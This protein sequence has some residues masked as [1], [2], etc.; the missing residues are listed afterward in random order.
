MC[1]QVLRP[2][3]GHRAPGG[4]RRGGR[5]HRRAVDRRAG[6]AAHAAH[7]PHRRRGEPHRRAVA[8][9]RPRTTARSRFVEPRDRAVPTTAIGGRASA[10]TARSSCSTPTGRVRQ[11][12]NVPYGAHLFVHGRPGGRGRAAALR[13]G[14]LQQAD[15]HREGAARCGSWTS[16]RRSR[17]ATRS[18]TPPGCKLLVIMEDRN[19][20][21]Q[22]AIDILD[23]GRPEARALPAADRGAPRGARR[24]DGRGRR[25]AG[26]DP[27]R[28]RPRPATSRAVCRASPSCSRRAGRRTRRSSPRSTARVEFGG[29]SRGMRKLVVRGDD[30]DARE[31]LI[32]QGKHLLRAGGQTAVRA[33]DRLTEG[34]INPHDILQ[35]QGHRGGAGVP[36]QRDPGGL[37]AAGRAHR[38][39]AHRGDRAPDAPEGAHRGSGRHRT[40]SRASRWTGSWCCEE[41]ER[42][43]ERGRAAGHLPAAAARDHQGLALDREL[44]LGG[45]LPGDHPGADRGGDPGQGGLPAG[46]QG[47]RHH[48]PPDPGRDRACPSYRK[49]RLESEKQAEP[50]LAGARADGRPKNRLTGTGRTRSIARSASATAHVVP[51]RMPWP[52]MTAQALSR[53]KVGGISCRR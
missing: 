41:N 14:P 49:L 10:A 44:H 30:G 24:P 32:P 22:P 46:P 27:P 20:E 23:A 36:G 40:S 12:Y 25:R 7:L 5:R 38:R 17:S 4:P 52:A 1:A 45:L 6:H 47:E 8:R 35:D 15:R 13:V 21:L 29:V 9:P 18:T 39:Q 37:P 48:R 50:T 51:S 31:Y 3:P 42:V 28:G 16:R 26:Q 19:K 2:Q 11:R 43:I 53:L 33:G 34:P